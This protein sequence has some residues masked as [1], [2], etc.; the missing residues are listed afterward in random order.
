[1]HQR[2]PLWTM[3]EAVIG[4]LFTAMG[5]IVPV[6]F[7]T[8]GLGRVFLPMHLPVLAAGFFVSPIVAAAVGSVTPW[9]SCFLTG[10]PPLQTAVLMSLE[11]PVLAAVA[12]LCYRVLKWSMW[13]ST[14]CAIVARITFDLTLLTLVVAPLL[15]LPR[16]AFG[17]A[18]VIAGMPGILLQAL[19]MPLIVTAFGRVR[20]WDLWMKGN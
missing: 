3:R 14:I 18:S 12:S 4:G 7:H 13:V 1:M 15:Q 9:V 2:R 16:G 11:L 17:L 10:M 6:V 19:T 20:G 5:V 8:F